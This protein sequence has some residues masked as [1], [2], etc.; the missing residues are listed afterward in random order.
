MKRMDGK[1]V[2]DRRQPR[3][4]VP[5]WV[6]DPFQRVQVRSRREAATPLETTYR[7]YKALVQ[8][9]RGGVYRALDVSCANPRSCILKEGRRHGETDWSGRDGFDRLQCEARFLR[10]VSR[11]LQ[12][13]PRLITT[14][15]ANNCFYLVMEPVTGRSLQSVIVGRERISKRRALAYCA[16]M[17]RIVADIHAAGWAWRDCK[18]GNFLCQKRCKLRALDF[19]GASPIKDPDPLAVATPGYLPRQWQRVASDPRAADLYALGISI[20]ELIAR[21]ISPTTR[22][23]AAFKREIRK[24]KLPEPLCETILRLRSPKSKTRSSAR[25]VQQMLEELLHRPNGS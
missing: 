21:K 11:R 16:S 8:R 7:D 20:M 22:L 12:A 4:A 10:A 18:P 13:V 9:G 23:A 3:S 1:L 24:Q 15:R 14:F 2:R 25:E 6:S 17:A 19:E 5:G